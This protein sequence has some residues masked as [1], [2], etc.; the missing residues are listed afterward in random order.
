MYPY[1]KFQVILET[2]DFGTKFTHEKINTVL[3]C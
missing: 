3:V 1:S 2:S